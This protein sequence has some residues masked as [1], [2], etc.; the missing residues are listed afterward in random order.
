MQTGPSKS[1]AQPAVTGHTF[2]INSYA[3]CA[4]CHGSAA[5][6][7]NLLVFVSA[8]ITN[9]IQSVQASL[10]HWALTK[11]PVL[12][13]TAQ[14][15]TRAWEYTKPG[16][17]SPGGPGPTPTLQAKIP[18]NIQKARFN[19]Y[20]VLYD[21]SLGAHNPLYDVTLLDTAQSWVDQELR[22]RAARKH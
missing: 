18:V 13:G 1:P 19:L 9:Q 6:A 21:G 14:Y 12:L 20:L 16:S 8:V 11:A 5:N 15:G 22:S 4:D 10:N 2:A 3:L 7:S 17:L